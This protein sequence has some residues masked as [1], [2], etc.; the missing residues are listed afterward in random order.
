MKKFL[1]FIFSGILIGCAAVFA[2]CADGQ[3]FDIECRTEGNGYVIVADKKAAAG[4]KII[5]AAKPD[6]GYKLSSFI[7]DG[8]DMEGCSFVMPDKSVT[9]S[10]RFEALTFSV[11]YVLGDATATGDNPATYTVESATELAPP[12]KEGYEVCAWYRYFPENDP[13][14]NPEEYRVSS[15]QGLYGN[16]TL[17]AKYYNPPHSVSVADSE[18]G[19]CYLENY[20]YEAYYGDTFNVVVMPDTGYELDYISVNGEPIEGTAFSMPKRDVEVTAVFKPVVYKIT[21]ELDGGTNAPDNPASFTVEDGTVEI[22]APTKS[23]FIFAGWFFD[24]DFRQPLYDSFY[25]YDHTEDLTL[26]A[27]FI[28][29]I[30]I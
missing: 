1:I 7:L 22:A 27:L 4:E 21:Y 24:E 8:E 3:K 11:T 25:T 6:A 30:I 14:A 9:V 5:L 2:A 20:G 18:N 26:Y 19:W 12:E 10:A 15:L 28:M 13:S 16:L 17:Y 23:G 29:D